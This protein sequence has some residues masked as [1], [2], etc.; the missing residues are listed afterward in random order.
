MRL[1]GDVRAGMRAGR[2]R[3]VCWIVSDDLCVQI[4]VKADVFMRLGPGMSKN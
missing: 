4:R 1:M 2:S 3:A